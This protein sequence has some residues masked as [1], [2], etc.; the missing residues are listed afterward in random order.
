VKPVSKGTHPKQV[1][2]LTADAFGILPPVAMLTKEQ[3]EYHF[4]SGYTAKLAEPGGRGD[5]NTRGITEPQATFSSCFGNAFLT[6]HPTIY[7]RELTRKMLEHGS[8]AYL[9]N[10]G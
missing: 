10:T 7:A 5:C 3:T 4:L 9:V 6:L 1:I 2:F 8:R